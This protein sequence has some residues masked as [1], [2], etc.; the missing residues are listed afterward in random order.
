VEPTEFCSRSRTTFARAQYE[1]RYSFAAVTTR[2]GDGL[3]T[4]AH[5]RLIVAGEA[6]VPHVADDADDFERAVAEIR[7][8]Q[9]FPPG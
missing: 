5:A 4:D 7:N 6:P 2:S 9:R 8:P 3:V 1:D